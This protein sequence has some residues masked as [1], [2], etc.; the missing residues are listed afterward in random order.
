LK[1]KLFALLACALLAQASFAATLEEVAARGRLAEKRWKLDGRPRGLAVAADGTVYVG[2]ATPQSVVAIDT[3]KGEVVREAVIDSEESAS[4]K[5]F[6]TLRIARERLYVAQGSDESVTILS[7]PGLEVVRE[8]LLEGEPVRDALPD[9]AGRHLYVLG[10]KVRVFDA[11]GE[12]EIRALGAVEP[13]AIATDAKGRVLAVVGL[14]AFPN[15][16]VSVAVFYDAATLREIGRVPLQT[17]RE[18][19]SAFFAADDRVLVA[20]ARDWLAEAPAAP[21][22][23]RKPGG[24]A[25]AMRMTIELGDLISSETIC[26]PD[27]AGPQIASPAARSLVV[28]AERRCAAGGAFTATKRR[29]RVASLYGI[30]AYAMAPTRDG[31]WAVTDPE[32]FLTIYKQPEP[33]EEAR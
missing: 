26:L 5:D 24:D 15:G 22:E 27:G 3:A 8:I 4:T 25:T 31:R 30:G 14:E 29:T 7:L 17:E 1:T 20:V 28:V 18:I 2:L 19:V 23:E 16:K 10:R 9:P 13:T 33:K 12:R 6:S 21:R 32:G 11:A